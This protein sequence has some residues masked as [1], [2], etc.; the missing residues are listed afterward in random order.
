LE[1]K[2]I[3]SKEYFRT[4]KIIFFALVAGQVFFA[5]V[6]FFLNKEMAMKLLD[7]E[8]INIFKYIV[9]VFIIGGYLSSKL[10]FR[11]GLQ[12]AISRQALPEKLTD[13]RAAL[14]MRYALFEGTSFFTIVIYLLSGYAIFL[15]YAIGVIIVFLTMMP[16]ANQAANDLQLDVNDQ[17]KVNNPDAV[18]M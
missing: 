15:G 16:S 3:T 12:T 11:K 13:Y 18:V 10:M 1:T 5:L 6:T 7:D 8:L 17:Q 4:L 9:P 14:I 2:P